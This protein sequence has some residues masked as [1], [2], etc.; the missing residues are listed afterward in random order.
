MNHP[1]ASE[2]EHAR[3]RGLIGQRGTCH[4]DQGTDVD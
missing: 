3:S 4:L 2:V 1:G